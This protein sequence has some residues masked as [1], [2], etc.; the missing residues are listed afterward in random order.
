M[1]MNDPRGILE[2]FAERASSFLPTYGTHA[3][4]VGISDDPGAGGK[5][6]R[7]LPPSS[8][9]AIRA[10]TRSHSAIAKSYGVAKSTIGMIRSGKRYADIE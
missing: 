3:I 9:R 7:C 2:E 8:I 4:R 5:A 1:S 6:L 10:D